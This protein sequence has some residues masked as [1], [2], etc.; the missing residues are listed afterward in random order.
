VAEGRD[1]MDMV[2]RD[3]L[4]DGVRAAKDPGLLGLLEHSV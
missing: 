4:S 1:G 2:A 3:D